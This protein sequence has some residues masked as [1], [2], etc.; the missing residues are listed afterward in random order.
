[1]IRDHRSLKS[2][3]LTI[4]PPPS[5]AASCGPPRSVPPA[6]PTLRRRDSCRAPRCRR[7]PRAAQPLHLAPPPRSRN[8]V[9]PPLCSL[10]ALRRPPSRSAPTLHARCDPA[11]QN[12]RGC[13]CIHLARRLR[14]SVH[15]GGSRRISAGG[16]VTMECTC[17]EVCHVRCG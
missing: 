13:P 4:A 8:A 16:R 3:A 17:R 6:P 11:P 10:V 2:P 14:P 7:P 1:M 5:S 15:P 12:R 9:P